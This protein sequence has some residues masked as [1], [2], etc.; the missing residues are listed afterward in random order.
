VLLSVARLV[1]EFCAGSVF[2][3]LLRLP[4]DILFPTQQTNKVAS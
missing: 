3:R 1:P 2:W 4:Y